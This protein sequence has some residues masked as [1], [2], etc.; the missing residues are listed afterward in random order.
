MTQTDQEKDVHITHHNDGFS[1]AYTSGQRALRTTFGSQ[2]AAVDAVAEWNKVGDFQMKLSPDVVDHKYDV[3]E[4][5]AKLGL[6][7]LAEDRDGEYFIEQIMALKALASPHGKVLDDVSKLDLDGSDAKQILRL[8]ND[9]LTF[10]GPSDTF[11]ETLKAIS[12]AGEGRSDLDSR[13]A[14]KMLAICQEGVDEQRL[15]APAIR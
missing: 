9:A 10:V 12:A 8:A 3:D 5:R 7:P 15:A 1:V 11:F 13:D 4:E 14:M 2:Q 6:K